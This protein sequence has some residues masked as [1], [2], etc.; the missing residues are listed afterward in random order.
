[1][2][3]R[4]KP[5]YRKQCKEYYVTIRGTQ[6][7][8]GPDK[9]E[10]YKRFHELMAK[11]E[12][13]IATGTVAEL[14]EQFMDWTEVNR[15]KSYEWYKKRIDKFYPIIAPLRISD[16]RPY[17]VQQELDKHEWSDAF[18]AG[19]VT[20]VKRVFN[21]S[22]DQ[23]Y[24]EHTPLRGLKKPDPGHREQIISQEQFDTAL[25]HVPN[26]NFHDIAEFIWYTGCRPE[27]AVK[28]TPDMVDL[29]LS[30][31]IVPRPEAKKKKRPR[32]I[33]LCDE[34]KEIVERNVGNS[35]TLFLNTKGNQWTAYAIACTW[36]RI[37]KKTGQRYC[38]YTL[39]HSYITHK[40]KTGT[41]TVT[42]AHLVGHEDTSMISK[43]YV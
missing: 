21:W 15:P 14:I 33:Y 36:G 34:A 10:A 40:L 38:S 32:L 24:I 3:R 2:A 30:R 35:P 17:H 39:R 19:C 22:V 7:R 42:L 26:R 25:S 16:I 11:P 43:I 18:K 1:M 12:R 23:G 9:K 27:E 4:P 37:E 5:W 13:A 20:A 31:I 8:L 6:H 29:A 28:I 41:D